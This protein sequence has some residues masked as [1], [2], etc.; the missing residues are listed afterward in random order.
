MKKLSITFLLFCMVICSA[1]NH[2]ARYERHRKE[3]F[4]QTFDSSIKEVSNFR[5]KN[6]SADLPHGE[7]FVQLY[8]FEARTPLKI[9]K[10]KLYKQVAAGKVI[11]FLNNKKLIDANDLEPFKINKGN[12]IVWES[13]KTEPAVA[14]GSGR[15]IMHITLTT[16]I[17]YI[18]GAINRYLVVHVQENKDVWK[19]SR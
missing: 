12:L 1:C 15:V 11:S 16:W 9:K 8:Q 10:H 13:G 18:P 19:K 5:G 3:L 17:A 4:A 2:E 14:S 7:M 6:Y